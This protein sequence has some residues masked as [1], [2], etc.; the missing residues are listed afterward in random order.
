MFFP[1]PLVKLSIVGS[2][3]DR[4]V[5]CSASYRR[6]SNFKSCV[7][8]TVSSYSSHHTIVEPSD[9]RVK[10]ASVGEV[11]ASKFSEN[12]SVGEKK[13]SAELFVFTK[14]SP[15]REHHTVFLLSWDCLVLRLRSKGSNCLLF[16]EAVTAFW[17]NM[18]VLLIVGVVHFW[19]TPP[20][21]QNREH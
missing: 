10:T 15:L 3:R 14:L 13:Y 6:G 17:L 19:Y 7:W 18:A 20:T 5:A 4:E 16:K 12:G 2:F 1:H 11:L 9:L 8:R 21:C